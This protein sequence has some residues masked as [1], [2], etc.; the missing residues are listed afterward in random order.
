M[1]VTLRIFTSVCVYVCVH[2]CVCLC[3][4]ERSDLTNINHSSVINNS[5]HHYYCRRFHFLSLELKVLELSPLF[6]KGH[7]HRARC[8]L[9][10]NKF[11]E[12]TMAVAKVRHYTT[13]YDSVLYYTTPYCCLFVPY[14]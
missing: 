7:L 6:P 14:N 3:V 4:D 2:A 13:L 8:L 5:T 1:A 12:A 10:L 9:Q 11:D